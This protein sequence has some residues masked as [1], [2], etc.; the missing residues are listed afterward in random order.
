MS[1]IEISVR[2]RVTVAMFT[3][4]V[5]LFGMV[6]LTRLK[7]NLLPDLSYPTLTVRTEYTGAAPTEVENL[8]SKPIEEAVGVVKN[9]R[10]VRSISRSGQSDVLVEFIWGTDMNFA[11]LDIREK[12]DAVLLPLEVRR[13]VIL[14]FDPSLDPIMRFSLA[15]QQDESP[16]PADEEHK[17]DERSR[18]QIV[19]AAQSLP[20]TAED[21]EDDL[22]Y[23]RR[24]AEEELK[25][26]LESVIGVASVKISGGLEDEI[27]VLMD[28]H[29]LSQL[30]LN[31]EDISEQLRLENV[32]LSGGRLEEGSRQYLVRTLN[33][34][35]TVDAIGEVIVAYRGGTPVYLKDIADIRRGYRERQAITR[36]NG[37]EA[38]EIAIYKEGDANTVK[39][40]SAVERRL[41]R[42]RENI[43]DDLALENVYNQSHFITQ[44]INSVINAAMLGGL[45]AVMVLYLFLR[46]IGSTVII[47]LAIPVSVIATFG[48]MY[49]YGLSLN[50]MSLGG[51]ALGIGLL[52]DNSIVV[53]EN[54]SR[55]RARGADARA[56][57]RDG[58]SEV[59]TAVT[60][61]TLTSVAVFFPLVFVQGI[62]GQLFRDQALTVT[63]AL[64]ASLLVAL[65]LIPMLASISAEKS[66]LLTAP[67]LVPP[68]TRPGKWLRHTRLFL[69]TT[70]PVFLLRQVRRLVRLASRGSGRLLGPVLDRFDRLYNRLEQAYGPLLRWSLSHR[71]PVIGSALALFLVA[72]LALGS[73]GVELIPQLS[74]GEFQMEILL[75][76]GAPLEATDEILARVQAEAGKLDNIDHTF[77][78]AGTGNR[79]DA[80]PEEGGENWGELTVVLHRGSSREDEQ[81]VMNKLRAFAE[82]IPGVSYKFGRATLFSFRTPI[83]VEVAGYNLKQL[84]RVSD[85][86]SARMAASG[87][88]AD[89]KSTMGSGHPEIQILFDRN[90]A[91]ALGLQVNLIAKRV[92]AHVRGD[93]ATRY[94]WRDRKID[95][96]VRAREADRSSVDDIRQIIINPDSERPVTLDAVAEIVVNMGPGEIHRIGQQRVSLVTANIRYGDLGAAAGELENILAGIPMP[97]GLSASITGQ[98]EQMAT[99]FKSL[100]IAL[101]MAVFL[102][103]LVMASQFESLIHPFV[104]L[105][106][107]PLALVGAVLALWITGSTIN[108][109]V[110]IGVIL[111]TG[112]VVNNA[113][114]L[115]DRINQLRQQGVE[116]RSAI[117][118]AGQLRLRPIL[119]TTLTTILGLL[120]L[121]LGRGDGAEIRAPMAVTV[122]G[123]LAVATLL[124]LVVIPV[125]YDLLDRKKFMPPTTG[126]T[127]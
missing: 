31:L 41:K 59:S 90:R 53:L 85:E 54:V 62:A 73:M 63:F 72:I 7:T 29:R 81:E 10:Q 77:A 111:L 65:T 58:A 19:M 46:D 119:M 83:E 3:V 16:E 108:V 75:P 109:V 124:T 51:I 20:S 95:I 88:F 32:N 9:V 38:V 71:G 15:M 87:R 112:I 43:P 8:I 74:Q 21:L 50:I 57:A 17:S 67:V 30:N 89:I 5:I 39:V 98:N 47:S 37:S 102:V 91:A 4:T 76:P 105:F 93:V 25:T 27:Q 36:M 1:I 123:G 60:A 126:A 44:A 68:K 52:V 56:A 18:S 48:L 116:K 23:L 33:Q 127:A 115:I 104:I 92:V 103:Y 79:M 11:S 107:V 113:I 35:K 80:N 12:I 120:P 34:F 55:H 14:R 49:G 110:L 84:K 40:A 118:Q 101:L 121:A 26:T 70:V 78:V 28:Q 69:L 2:R 22:K 117:I 24:Y 122:I 61:S 66:V 6:A 125:A 106:T 100:R 13:P 114:V 94:A 97:T 86:I 42:I 45:L 96:I 64:V 99:S 82:K